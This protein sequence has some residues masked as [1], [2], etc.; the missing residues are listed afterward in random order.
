MRDTQVAI[1]A[2][3]LQHTTCGKA[4]ADGVLLCP[5]EAGLTATQPALIRADPHDCLDLGPPTMQTAHLWGHQRQAIG[6]L[7]LLAVSDHEHVEAPTQPA[8]L[9][10]V[11]MSPMVTEGVT[12]N[13]TMLVEP[14]DDIPAVVAKALQQD[15][16]GIP[17]V[18]E[19]GLGTT[20]QA[21]AGITQPLQ[22]QRGLR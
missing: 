17:G 21:M 3:P 5:D 22:R 15:L 8:I 9:G 19:P 7:V 14:A 13:P 6:G 20:T 11:G 10:P 12:M 1:M 16:R 4:A 2:F 18:K